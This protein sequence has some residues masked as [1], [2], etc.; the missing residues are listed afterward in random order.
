M[1]RVQMENKETGKKTTHRTKKTKSGK[2]QEGT[3]NS[4]PTP[5]GTSLSVVLDKR[6][7]T[8]QNIAVQFSNKFS[9][10][11]DEEIV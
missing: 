4:G 9:A 1:G 8:S 10:K 7:L 2:M 11:I 3:N 5:P 6:A